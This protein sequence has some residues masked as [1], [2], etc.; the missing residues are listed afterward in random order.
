MT[1]AELQD[2]TRGDLEAI[3]AIYNASI[4]GRLATADL[5]PV[6]VEERVGWFERHGR[7][8]PLWVARSAGRVAGWLSFEDFYGRPAYHRTAEVS[9]YVAPDCQRLGI[10]GQLL[11]AAVQRAPELGLAVLL[12][13]VFGHNTPSLRLFAGFG[14]EAAGRLP[15]VAELDGVM[16]DLV[17]VLRRL[18]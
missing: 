7:K 14:F 3:V 6:L 17:I 12:G 13:F 15:A 2:A 4:S 9:V 11:G 10:G 18:P 1:R 5:E 8:R 16:R